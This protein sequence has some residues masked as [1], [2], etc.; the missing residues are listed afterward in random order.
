MSS[1]DHLGLAV[2]SKN[3][4]SF[5]CQ[6]D[7]LDFAVATKFMLSNA[8]VDA[9]VVQ[10]EEGV[11]TTRAFVKDLPNTCTRLLEIFTTL[12]GKV[13]VFIVP[14][15][16]GQCNFEKLLKVRTANKGFFPP[17]FPKLRAGCASSVQDMKTRNLN[18]PLLYNQTT[19]VL[20]RFAPI[21]VRTVL[22]LSAALQV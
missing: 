15:P 6:H 16:L 19:E 8:D 2:L 21:R 12:E 4:L 3:H 7:E 5:R 14:R 1:S 9:Y 17:F 11:I 18:E 10:R 13:L 22:G 20:V